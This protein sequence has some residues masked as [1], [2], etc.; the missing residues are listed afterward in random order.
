MH[1]GMRAPFRDVWRYDGARKIGNDVW[2]IRRA[3]EHGFEAWAAMQY[4]CQHFK[5]VDLL[6][7]NMVYD[8]LVRQA[9]EREL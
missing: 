4:P 5:T 9:G 1:T 7:V 8:A 6:Q 2:F 3:I